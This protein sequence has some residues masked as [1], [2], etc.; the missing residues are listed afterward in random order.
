MYTRCRRVKAKTPL[1][2]GNAVPEVG[3]ELHSSPC[4]HWELTETCGI[5]ASPAGIRPDPTPTV[6]TLSTPV[7][8]AITTA[9]S[10][11]AVMVGMVRLKN[12][13]E[14]RGTIWP[15][16]S[17][18]RPVLLYLAGALTPYTRNYPRYPR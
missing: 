1:T 13:E 8:C 6:L 16:T 17:R 5:R 2:R 15:T 11:P 3:L 18:W 14:V 12:S 10:E 7:S 4:K 9:P